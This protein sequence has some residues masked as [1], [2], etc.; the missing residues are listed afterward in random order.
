M[1]ALLF[2]TLLFSQD[3]SKDAKDN[4]TYNDVVKSEMRLPAEL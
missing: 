1:A 3:D 2:A 4:I